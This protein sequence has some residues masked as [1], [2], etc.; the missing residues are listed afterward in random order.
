M[1]WRNNMKDIW[2]SYRHF[3]V[4]VGVGCKAIAEF[5]IGSHI[6]YND[7]YENSSGSGKIFAFAQ[8]GYEPTAWIYEDTTQDV[9]CVM[10]GW[11]TL[12]EE[13]D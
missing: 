12:K 4:H 6:S 10:L 11:C 8:Q 1:I 5:K 3:D 2:D 9:K 13:E 7:R